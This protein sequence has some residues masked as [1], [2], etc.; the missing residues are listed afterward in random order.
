MSIKDRGLY[1]CNLHHLYCH[2]YET[3]R[4]Q[5]NVTKSRMYG[6]RSQCV[7]QTY[8]TSIFSDGL[9]SLPKAAKSSASGMDKRRCTWF[10]SEAPWCCPAS[11][12]EPCGRTGATRRRTSR[13]YPQLDKS[14]RQFTFLLTEKSIAVQVVHWDRQ[15]PGIRHDRADRLVDL[16]ASGEQR[17]YGPLFL[18]GKMNIS[19]QAFSEGDFSLTILDLQVCMFERKIIRM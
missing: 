7:N 8:F 10:C 12:D 4:V 6:F 14:V 19:N 1:S 15:P 13:W 5:L 18:Q 17:S 2:L 3:V 16:Y 9:P 11:T